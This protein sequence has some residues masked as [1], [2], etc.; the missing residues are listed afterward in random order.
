MRPEEVAVQR[1]PP[2][3][4]ADP[5]RLMAFSITMTRAPCCA[6]Y[7]AADIPAMPAPSTSR[8]QSRLSLSVIVESETR[9]RLKQ[10]HARLAGYRVH[11][12]GPTRFVHTQC[13]IPAIG[14]ITADKGDCPP[15]I[16]Q[17]N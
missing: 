17:P 4:K 6:A 10:H 9:L 2:E 3:S 15:V 12:A 7:P 1:T 5:P 13:A 8:S 16:T 14:Q 11:L